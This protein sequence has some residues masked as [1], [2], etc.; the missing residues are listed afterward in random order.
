VAIAFEIYLNGEKICTAG[1]GR[2]GVLTA[3][4]GWVKRSPFVEEEE[5]SETD[6]NDR[7]EETY[8]NVSGLIGNDRIGYE[9]VKWLRQNLDIGDLVTVKVVDKFQ[10]RNLWDVWM[11]AIITYNFYI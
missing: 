10:D 8:I 3:I 4:L 5:G 2:F 9:S 7:E 1:V 11:Y 6:I